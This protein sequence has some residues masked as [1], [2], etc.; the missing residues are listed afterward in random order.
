MRGFSSSTRAVCLIAALA[1]ILSSAAGCAKRRPVP[2]PNA[3]VAER[4]N[5][6][7]DPSRSDDLR[8]ETAYSFAHEGTSTALALSAAVRR[9]DDPVT[10]VLLFEALASMKSVDTRAIFRG[11][12]T[13]PDVSGTAAY[14]L[15]QRGDDSGEQVLADTASGERTD[16]GIGRSQAAD[17][18]KLLRG[19]R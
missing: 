2:G 16:A 7:E 11:Y 10:K 17:G 4:I 18:L 15:A 9:S 14:L 5:V 3:S 13:D 19:E 12:L 8:L 6:L 1:I